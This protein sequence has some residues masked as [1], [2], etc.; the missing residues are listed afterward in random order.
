MP[1]NVRPQYPSRCTFGRAPLVPY[2]AHGEIRLSDP[3]RMDVRP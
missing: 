2:R 3:R 1:Q